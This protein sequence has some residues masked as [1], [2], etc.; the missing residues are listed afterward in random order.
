M[1][2]AKQIP[3]YLDAHLGRCPRCMRQSFIFMLG[4]WGLVLVLLFATY[5]STPTVTS[6]I[7]ATSLTIL[8]LS[9]LTAFAL[10]AARNGTPAMRGMAGANSPSDSLV[11]PRRRFILAFTK[12]AAFAA[13]ATAFPFGTVFAQTCPCA[14]PLKCCYSTD[15]KYYDCAPSD[16]MCCG[17]PTNPWHCNSGQRC[18]GSTPSRCTPLG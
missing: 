12:G 5:S 2:I 8:W 6:A 13:L 18:D 15:A 14:A 17:D 9:H 3:A 7:V 1:M 10:R 4:A 16:A 11:Q